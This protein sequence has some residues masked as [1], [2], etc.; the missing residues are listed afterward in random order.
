MFAEVLTGIAL[1][2]KSVDFIKNNISTAKDIGAI[3]QQ[4]DD[5]FV[6]KQQLDSKR[7]KKSGI[8]VADQFGVKSVATEIIDAKLA[9]EKMYEISVLVDIRFGSGTWKGIIAERN[10]RINEAKEAAKK[11]AKEQAQ[12]N[13]QMLEIG[14]VIACVV[15]GALFLVGVAYV[16]TK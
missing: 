9:A 4:I 1:V 12:R 8:G 11:A 7:S 13:Q 5:L 14:A 2:N 3:A 16:L 10:K 15:V 6:G